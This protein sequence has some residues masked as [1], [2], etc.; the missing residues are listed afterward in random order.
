[1]DDTGGLLPAG[2]SVTVKVRT[3]GQFRRVSLAGM[4]VPTNDAFVSLETDLPTG[5][6][7]SKVVYAY[8]Y[9]AGTEANDELCASIPGPPYAECGGPGGGGT[10]GG[11]EGFVHVHRGMRGVGDFDATTRDWRNPVA[12]VTITRIA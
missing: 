2:E 8:A 7:E 10:V 1:M 12:R 4:L 3:R 5:L 9:D 6:G 11:G